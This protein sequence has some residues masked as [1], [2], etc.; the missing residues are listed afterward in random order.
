M[1]WIILII[2]ILIGSFLNVCIYRIPNNQSVS[3]PPSSC[4]NCNTRIKYYDLIPIVS[5]VLLKGRCRS[6]GEKISLRYPSIEGL[7]GILYFLLYNTYGF[8]LSTLF[9]MPIVSILIVVT[10]ID[11]DHMI[12]P[13]RLNIMLG[14]LG[15]INILLGM[16]PVTA[17]S[18]LIGAV[19]GFGFF[20]LI[21]IVTGGQ[22]GGGDIFLMGVLGLILGLGE[23]LM[24][25]V[26]S[27]I[28][29]AV[30]SVI[31]L[32]TKIKGRKDPIPFGPFIALSAVLVILFGN[33]ILYFYYKILL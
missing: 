32:L 18:S 24:V 14:I 9:F 3:Y 6:C 11:Y 22:M 15:I 5:Y 25:T 7:N 13:Y 16:Y 29:G 8:S 2:G 20:F 23:I 31:L 10:F 4:S 33:D 26:L 1:E 27:F 19:L 21:A 17:K 28:T 30:I 12:I